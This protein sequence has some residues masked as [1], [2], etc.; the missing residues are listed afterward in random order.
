MRSDTNL[1]FYKTELV[2]GQYQEFPNADNIT[3][4]LK[5]LVQIIGKNE[6]QQNLNFE[7][8]QSALEPTNLSLDEKNLIFSLL[9]DI[10]LPVNND[11]KDDYNFIK[12]ELY[13]A[14]KKIDIKKSPAKIEEKSSGDPIDHKV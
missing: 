5:K 13:M 11:S 7:K 3:R 2:A 9:V 1:S 14:Q 8:N 10:G 4:R 6:Y 12:N